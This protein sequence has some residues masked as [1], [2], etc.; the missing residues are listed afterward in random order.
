MVLK[1]QDIV[2]EGWLSKHKGTSTAEATWFVLAIQQLYEF[3]SPNE[4]HEPF[5]VMSMREVSMVRAAKDETGL[6]ASFH[7]QR[8]DRTLTLVAESEADMDLWLRQLLEKTEE[9]PLALLVCSPSGQETCSGTYELVLDEVANDHAVWQKHDGS[10]WLFSGPDGQWTI[11]GE[12]AKA[13]GFKAEG[14]IHHAPVHDGIWPD[15][16]RGD[17]QWWDDEAGA[18]KADASILVSAEAPPPLFRIISPVGQKACSGVYELVA[19]KKANGY[20]L[21]QKRGS[22]ASCWLYMGEHH[23]WTVGGEGASSKDFQCA[24]GYIFH[25]PSHTGAW[26]HKHTGGWQRWDSKARAW[27][28]DPEIRIEIIASHQFPRQHST[29]GFARKKTWNNEGLLLEEAPSAESGSRASVAARKAAAQQEQGWR[30][31][32]LHEGTWVWHVES[33]DVVAWDRSRYGSFVV[34]FSYIV[35]HTVSNPAVDGLAQHIFIWLGESTS[36]DEMG[37]A[38]HKAMEL[39]D[40]FE[41]RTMQHRE[42]M[43]KE[44]EA[45]KSIFPSLQY[46]KL[47][48]DCDAAGK[49]IPA[50]H[51]DFVP[52]L[53][54]IRRLGKGNMQIREV[55]CSKNSL[56]E[57]DCFILDAGKKLYVWCGESASPFEKN[58]AGSHAENLENLRDGRAQATHNIDDEF[59]EMLGDGRIKAADEVDDL[60]KELEHRPN[61]LF[62]VQTT[63]DE[64]VY[65][66]GSELKVD[67]VATGELKSGMLDSGHIML[68]DT[69]TE[70]CLWIGA[71][72]PSVATRNAMGIAMRFLKVNDK[73]TQTPITIL[74]ERQAIATQVW[75]KAFSS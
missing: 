12:Q 30:G 69:G 18:W 44:S 37:T 4:F 29:P 65:C 10:R 35:L 66:A 58:K 11:G 49:H 28:E 32:G 3:A 20:P 36:V 73:P 52:K 60:D 17:W 33:F 42:V 61:T 54:H 50:F 8:F 1:R 38:A 67:L 48:G 34:G 5:S 41:G 45:F 47:D 14:H 59:W 43:G 24:S 25:A 62:K 2:K 21:W 27:L 57:G 63:T 19:G 31:A 40:L 75:L 23:Q 26:A 53:L 55:E 16:L 56:N 39:D 51:V 9:C 6:D 22:S 13:N 72:T 68:L 71:R 64:G 70:I 15:K 7:L 74:K 46:M